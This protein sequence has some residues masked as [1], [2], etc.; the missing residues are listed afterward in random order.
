MKDNYHEGSACVIAWD[1]MVQEMEGKKVHPKH[2]LFWGK[3]QVVYLKWK[4]TG[5]FIVIDKLNYHMPYWVKILGEWHMQCDCIVLITVQSAN[6][7]I[8][9]EL[10]IKSGYVD[11][12]GVNSSQSQ[13]NPPTPLPNAGRGNWRRDTRC[14]TRTTGTMMTEAEA[15]KSGD[16]AA[17]AEAEGS[18]RVVFR[19]GVS[20]WLH[21]NIFYFFISCYL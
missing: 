5:T 1:D 18:T 6:N 10:E 16:M 4:C 14:T 8:C 17:A 3:P 15:S 21:S 13:D 20:T 19:V 12:F 2:G 9:S 11:L 7:Q